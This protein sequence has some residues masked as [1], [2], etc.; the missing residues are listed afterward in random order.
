[1]NLLAA[2]VSLPASM[3]I[4]MVFLPNQR[5]AS[6]DR[7]FRQMVTG[8]AGVQFVG[9]AALAVAHAA[10]MVPVIHG[11]LAPTPADLP[12]AAT[13]YYEGAASLM[14]AL[15]SFV[16][17]VICRYSVRYLDGEAAQGR[18]FRWASFTIGA[19]SHMVIS[20][21]L[22][23]FILAWMMTSLGRPQDTRLYRTVRSDRLTSEWR[24]AGDGY[25]DTR[26]GID[27]CGDRQCRRVTE[28]PHPSA[29]GARRTF[30][31]CFERSVQC[32]APA[33]E[34]TGV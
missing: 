22:L 12:I 9:A 2:L 1:M 27:A 10:G 32:I 14:L 11:A 28:H 30:V 19:V 17:W 15:V 13:V 7:R 3:L 34:R 31:C 6:A 4:L 25:P 33:T 29:G 26:I 8:L 16:G 5:S 21:N 18:Y 20:G 23:M 24:H